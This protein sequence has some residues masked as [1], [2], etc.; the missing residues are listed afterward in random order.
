MLFNSSQYGSGRPNP[1]PPATRRMSARTGPGSAPGEGCR[2]GW[3]IARS[4]VPRSVSMGSSVA[5]KPGPPGVGPPHHRY[6]VWSGDTS[7]PSNHYPLSSNVACQA[8]A[9]CGSA[10]MAV[11]TRTTTMRMEA[12]AECAGALPPHPRSIEA[13]ATGK[14]KTSRCG[15]GRFRR[16]RWFAVQP[17]PQAARPNAQGSRGSCPG[18]PEGAGVLPPPTSRDRVRRGTGP[19]RC[20]RGRTGRRGWPRARGAASPCRGREACPA[21]FAPGPRRSRWPRSCGPSA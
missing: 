14:G 12:S 19:A 10:A 6:K 15:V 1:C 18:W 7:Q 21:T 3:R 20:P 17:P 9:R 16:V 11:R 4:T 8:C 5:G 2:A 13:R